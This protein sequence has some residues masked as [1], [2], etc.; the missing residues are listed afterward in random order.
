M[1]PQQTLVDVYFGGVRLGVA[2]A[3]YRPGRITFAAPAKV[4]ALL[5]RLVDPAAVTAALGG[6]LPSHPELVCHDGLPPGCGELLPDVAGV[7]FDESRF[8]VEVF[9][10]PRQLGVAGAGGAR[11]LPEP[12]AGA[13]VISSIAGA[14][15][16]GGAP[17][18]GVQSR[19]ILAWRAA[20]FTAEVAA[21][22]GQGVQAETLAAQVDRP[23]VRYEAG[24]FWAP[25]FDFTGQARMYGVGFGSQFDTREDADQ[26]AGAPLVVFLTHRSQVDILRDGRLLSSRLYDA[27]N[28]TLDTTYLPDGAYTVTLRIHDIDG[29]TRDLRQFFVKSHA[30]PPPDAPGFFV[31]AGVLAGDTGGPGLPAADKQLLLEVGYARRLDGGTSADVNALVLGHTVLGEAGITHFDRFVSLH[32]AALAASDGN[33]GVLF[34]GALTGI[35][36]LVVSLDVRK[37]WGPG[38][39]AL[40]GG[41]PADVFS[42]V[43]QA[44]LLS[45]ASLQAT[46]NVSYVYKGAQLGLTATYFRAAGAPRSF[47]YGPQL[48]WPFWQGQHAVATLGASFTKSNDGYQGLVSL[49]LQLFHGQSSVVADAG[50]AT[51]NGPLTGRKAGPVASVVAAYVRP[52]VLSSVLTLSGQASHTLDEDVLGGGAELRGAYGDFVGQAEDDV[53]AGGGG[54]LRYSANFSTSLAVSARGVAIGGAEVAASGIVAQLE[55]APA[56]LVADVL[57]NGAPAARLRGGKSAP[58]FLAPYRVYRV[59]LRPVNGPAV[60]FDDD[61][62]RQIDLFPGNIQALTWKVT[63]VMSVFGRAVDA[64]G[65]PIAAAVIEGAREPAETDDH[66]YFQAEVAAGARLTLRP[67]AGEVCRIALPPLAASQGFARLGDAVCAPVQP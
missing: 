60:A 14:V 33:Y 3:S 7:I 15:S 66:G 28:Q 39:T 43:S 52:D 46:G 50:V 1:R 56:D 67:A 62:D 6:E 58:V 42:S 25:A 40:G 63:P 65:R 24:L 38:L 16:G 53:S 11:Y 61:R 29:T 30:L 57:I 36:R 2:Q 8:A 22:T 37:T 35:P 18:F 49:R 44:N 5:P 19:T 10:N 31:E 51:E 23:G 12:T 59:S 4:T 41:Q 64:A 27:G 45:G 34:D 9:V 17:S 21:S 48:T 26:F 20:R 13:S 55:G 47:S 32:A 54:S